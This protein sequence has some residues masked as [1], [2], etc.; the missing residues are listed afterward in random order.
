MILLG[1]LFVLSA[2][3]PGHTEPG[4]SSP[5]A[6]ATEHVMFE[7]E[8]KTSNESIPPMDRAAPATFETAAFGLG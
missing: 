2:A 5:V 6:T 1:G 4:S 3:F 7:T 8:L